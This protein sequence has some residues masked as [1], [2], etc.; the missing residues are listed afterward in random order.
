MVDKMREG[1][2]VFL[3]LNGILRE[4]GEMEV[5]QGW[6]LKKKFRN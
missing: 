6:T 3:E 1:A 4:Q 2:T 5:G